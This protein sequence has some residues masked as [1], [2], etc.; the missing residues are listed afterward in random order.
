MGSVLVKKLELIPIRVMPRLKYDY[1]HE[2]FNQI[3]LA[4]LCF[5]VCKLVPIIPGL[6][7]HFFPYFYN[8]NYST[9]I[10]I[11]NSLL[12]SKKSNEI[13]LYN[14]FKKHQNKPNNQ[15]QVNDFKQQVKQLSQKLKDILPFNLRHKIAAHRDEKF[16]HCD[17]CVAYLLPDYLEKYISL[18][19]DL[20]K[21]FCI[22]CNYSMT[23]Y[24]NS[25]IINQVK[26]TLYFLN[27]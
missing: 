24:P 9:G 2:I 27:K 8:L 26:Q 14:Y 3:L 11:L 20:K 22:F 15:K 4:E 17:F 10:I 1:E 5:K 21:I 7:S 23:N 6:G 16:K 13:S 25:R 18:T 19:S 12:I